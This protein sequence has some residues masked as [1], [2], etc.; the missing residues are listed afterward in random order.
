MI[1]LACIDVI[2]EMYCDS[3]M[4]SQHWGTF[5]RVDSRFDK[6]IYSL[7]LLTHAYRWT[8]PDDIVKYPILWTD[9][10]VKCVQHLYM[11]IWR[12]YLVLCKKCSKYFRFF[13]SINSKFQ[14]HI[15]SFTRKNT[16]TCANYLN[17][18]NPNSHLSEHFPQT[19]P[20]RR[21]KTHCFDIIRPLQ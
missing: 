14:T 20:N 2:Y 4:M 13:S 8:T 3:F 15:S 9:V 17:E 5:T 18:Q 10:C 6:S 12:L 11:S 7:K 16:V 19:A 21:G 1:D